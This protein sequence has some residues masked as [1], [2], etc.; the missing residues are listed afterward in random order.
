MTPGV[1]FVVVLYRARLRRIR[2]LLA[3]IERSPLLRGA[4]V[5]VVLNRDELRRAPARLRHVCRAPAW[6][7][8]VAVQGNERGVAGAYN[9]AIARA[10]DDE[11]VVLLD[12]DSVLSQAYLDAL[13]L[14]RGGDAGTLRFFAPDLFDG[15][16]RVSP[17]RLR[18]TVPVPIA[19]PLPAR[20]LK[21]ADGLGVINAGL[22]GRAAAFRTVRGFDERIGLDLSDV[23]WSLSAAGCGAEVE[24]VGEA[25]P[26]ALSMASGRFG[27]RRLKKYIGACLRLALGRGDAVGFVQLVLRG[28]RAAGLGLLR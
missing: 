6:S 27:G 2:P 22:A 4:L 21:F 26:H 5:D 20:V 7:V 8:E 13:L 28:L 18:R 24:V 17:Y 9:H 15:A 23:A 11:L 10:H 19:G 16:L 25:Q 1:R 3:Q 12:S 14:C